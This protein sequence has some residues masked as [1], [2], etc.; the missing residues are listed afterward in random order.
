MY[1]GFSMTKYKR[2]M[3]KLNLNAPT[4]KAN[5]AISLTYNNKI[6]AI[7]MGNIPVIFDILNVNVNPVSASLSYVTRNYQVI[8]HKDYFENK[9]L[10]ANDGTTIPLLIQKV[11]AGKDNIGKD[12]T[13]Y[14]VKIT[15]RTG[16]N[17]DE[18][19]YIIPPFEVNYGD[20]SDG[21]YRQ[22]L[23]FNSLSTIAY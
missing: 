5:I 2:I 18:E 12:N 16:T 15:I 7:N 19:G 17:L 1:R 10:T 13:G 3:E 14:V 11:I 23:E 9:V 20:Y 21:G 4:H 22:Y 8:V 6:Y